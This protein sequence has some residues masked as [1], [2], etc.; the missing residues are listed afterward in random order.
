[1]GKELCWIRYLLPHEIK[2]RVFKVNQVSKRL[3]LLYYL[4]KA[5]GYRLKTPKKE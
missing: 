5:K 2:G 4:I 3:V 1:M